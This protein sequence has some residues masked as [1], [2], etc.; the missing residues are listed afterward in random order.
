MLA[1]YASWK[2][3]VVIDDLS[4]E[5][6]AQTSVMIDEQIHRASLVAD[7]AWAFAQWTLRGVFLYIAMWMMRYGGRELGR[8]WSSLWQKADPRL[9]SPY[10]QA[11]RNAAAS[12]GQ[13]WRK[14]VN[15]ALLQTWDPAAVRATPEQVGAQP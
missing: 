8:A 12:N 13:P 2:A 5:I 4:H 11:A 6:A 7:E 10:A 3:A 9:P 14:P 15:P 1:G